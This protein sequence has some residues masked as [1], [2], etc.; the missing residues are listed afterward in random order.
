MFR[1]PYDTPTLT[2]KVLRLASNLQYGPTKVTFRFEITIVKQTQTLK[3]NK[4]K[5]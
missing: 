2:T 4:R 3:Y 1:H 5:R